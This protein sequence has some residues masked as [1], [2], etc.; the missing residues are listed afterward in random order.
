MRLSPKAKKVLEVMAEEYE[1]NPETRLKGIHQRVVG[2]KAG[3]YLNY[4]LYEVGELEDADLVRRL[5]GERIILTQ[6]G[7]HHARPLVR[8][9][10][11]SVK[12]HPAITVISII[13]GII[14]IVL[15]IITLLS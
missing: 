10:L 3:I 8:R 13:V 4:P 15:A 14:T 6:K 11:N 1:K 5:G 12:E 9:W 7:Y 2:A